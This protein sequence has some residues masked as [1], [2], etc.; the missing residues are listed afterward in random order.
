MAPKR[1]KST[2]TVASKQPRWVTDLERKLKV[3]VIAHQAGIDLDEQ[4]QSE[5]NCYRI[6]FIE[7]NETNNYSRRAYI[8]YVETS[9]NLDWRHTQNCILSSM[10]IMTQA[11]RL[12]VVLK[13]NA[14]LYYSVEFTACS[15]WFEQ[16]K[17]LYSLHNLKVSGQSASAD[18]KEAE[19]FL[20][21]L[22]TLILEE[23][24]LPRQIFN[25]DETF[26]FWKRMPESS[27]IHK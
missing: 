5:G 9:N 24:Y 23:N 14:G 11:K 10:M 18:A 13:E 25:V 17:N 20:E 1:T 12:F 8:R 6:C 16:F 7:S 21:T 3:M 26:I 19:E 22:D 2:A 27:F 15:G 4:E